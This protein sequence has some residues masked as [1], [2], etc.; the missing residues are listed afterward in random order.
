MAQK[1]K[2]KKGMGDINI[3]PYKY[4]NCKGES[5][6]IFKSLYKVIYNSSIFYYFR[7]E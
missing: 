6:N 1:L 5:M 7:D 4:F 3:P 2:L